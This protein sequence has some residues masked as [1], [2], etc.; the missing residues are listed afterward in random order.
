[1]KKELVIM[2]SSYHYR[3]DKF[4][5]SKK[6][7]EFTGRYTIDEEGV[8]TSEIIIWHEQPSYTAKEGFLWWKKITKHPT[9]SYYHRKWVKDSEI[10]VKVVEHYKCKRD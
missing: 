1:M 4:V 7:A 5:F 2:V 10:D 3:I 9:K 8:I 6:D